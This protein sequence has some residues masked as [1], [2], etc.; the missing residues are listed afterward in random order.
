MPFTPFHFCVGVAAHSVSPR[1][2][3]FLSF[4]A[5]N[6]LIDVEPLC[7]MITGNCPLHRFFH[8]FAGAG[9]AAVAV[10]LGGY[11]LPRLFR[12][13][14]PGLLSL[15]LGAALGAVTHV[16]LDS[17]MHSDTRPFFPFSDANPMLGLL[18]VP[19]LHF[20]C[21]GLGAAGAAVMAFRWKRMKKTSN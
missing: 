10:I 18:S 13:R 17:V 14:T 4:C 8:S 20:L 1:K 21:L 5:V 15:A 2:V 12:L 3:S 6:V 16:V 7:M 9:L 19:E 11:L